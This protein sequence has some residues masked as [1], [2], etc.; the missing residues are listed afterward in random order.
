M[1]YRQVRFHL[2]NHAVTKFVVVVL[3]ALP[4][5]FQFAVA[6]LMAIVINPFI[7]AQGAGA[8]TAFALWMAFAALI[9]CG[10]TTVL[11]TVRLGLLG[12]GCNVISIPTALVIPFCI[13]ALTEGGPTTLAA[14]VAVSGLFQIAVSMRL[15]LL[16]RVVTPL[17]SGTVM[18]LVAVTLFSV[19]FDMVGNVPSGSPPLAAPLCALATLAVTLVILLRGSAVWRLWGPVIGIGIG[20]AVAG[21][22]GIYDF[23]TLNDAPWVGFPSSG[24]PGFGFD[25]GNSFWVLLPG[26]L[27]LSVIA[28]VQTNAITLATQ[29]VSWRSARAIDDRRIQGGALSGALGNILAGLS[30]TLPVLSLGLGPMLVKQTGTASRRVGV[31][32]GAILVVLAFFPKSWALLS[33]IPG[34]I[35]G[36]YLIAL[37]APILVE[38]ITSSVQDGPGYRRS[39]LVGVAIVVGMGFEFELV[40]LPIGGLWGPMLQNGLTSGGITIIVLSMLVELGSQSRRRLNTELSVEALPRVNEFLK[41]FASSR[42]WDAATVGRLE[43]VAEETLLVLGAESDTGRRLLIVAAS[44]G[45]MAELEFVSAPS[46]SENLEDRITYMKSSAWDEPDGLGLPDLAAV[47]RDLPLRILQHYASSV[48]H[49][50]YHEVEVVTVRVR[51]S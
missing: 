48:S 27:F 49:R 20:C 21:A 35:Y 5:A 47:S 11:Q 44:D 36:A 30:G 2:K 1:S 26:F 22:F 32:L 25:F 29:R 45:V 31:L 17:V 51:A 50:Q 38:G 41:G 24:W 34:P 46:G 39:L 3:V 37:I 15:S 7:V 4:S 12:A 16:R 6:S 33:V 23:E 28:V 18:V 42:N 10:L 8:N 43:E 9:V 13:L 40:T 19:A 14:L